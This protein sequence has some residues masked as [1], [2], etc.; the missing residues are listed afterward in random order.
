MLALG[1]A[2]GYGELP[3]AGRRRRPPE[4][5]TLETNLES[6]K[7][8]SV[9]VRSSQLL[10]HSAH[11]G[12]HCQHACPCTIASPPPVCTI[13]TPC[14]RPS[15]NPSRAPRT[16]APLQAAQ[17]RACRSATWRSRRRPAG[18]L[19][20][21]RRRAAGPQRCSEHRELNR[22]VQCG[23]RCARDA[24]RGVGDGAGAPTAAVAAQAAA[25]HSPAERRDAQCAWV[26]L[27]NLHVRSM[28][29]RPC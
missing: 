29:T 9:Q 27:S 21:E 22:I 24:G 16:G 20:L 6:G 5:P 23:C 26:P 8:L 18:P 11:L 19:L 13:A 4:V 3:T 17:H 28:R 14:S 15:T 12:Q 1:V 7:L 2:T 25:Q 10:P